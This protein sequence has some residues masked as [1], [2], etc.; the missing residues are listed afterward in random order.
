MS[1]FK[2]KF[3]LLQTCFKFNVEK[4]KMNVTIHSMYCSQVHMINPI[5][6]D[7]VIEDLSCLLRTN[8]HI[9]HFIENTI[10]VE[11]HRLWNHYICN[12]QLQD[13]QSQIVQ[14]NHVFGLYLIPWLYSVYI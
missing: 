8:L 13:L 12:Y 7:K 10:L 11:S 6:L 9:K 3:Q 14:F 2:L 4:R 5:L 1:S